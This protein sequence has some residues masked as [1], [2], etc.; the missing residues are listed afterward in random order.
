MRL[1]ESRGSTAQAFLARLGATRGGSSGILGYWGGQGASC[2]PASLSRAASSSNW[3]RFARTPPRPGETRP[4]DGSSAATTKRSTE[5]TPTTRP[6][7]Q[8]TATP[9]PKPDSA[10][11]VRQRPAFVLSLVL[12]PGQLDDMCVRKRCRGGVGLELLL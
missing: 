5:S 6:A 3:V 8:P 12:G 9:Q 1:S 7:C 2:S 11:A 10:F 4:H